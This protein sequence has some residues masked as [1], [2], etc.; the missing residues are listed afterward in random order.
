MEKRA[1]LNFLLQNPRVSDKKLDFTMRKP[2][3]VVL[4][5]ASHPT[6]LA[7]VDDFLTIDWLAEYPAPEFTLKQI[8][9][10]IL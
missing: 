1:I 10:L 8:Q 9:E 7:L 6:G 4:E 3:D 2:F 5:L